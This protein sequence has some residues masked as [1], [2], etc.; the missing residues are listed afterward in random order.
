MDETDP[1][2]GKWKINDTPTADE[3]TSN[4]GYM[5]G[6][7]YFTVEHDHEVTKF[8]GL[9]VSKN[10]DE[11]LEG[12]SY[13]PLDSSGVNVYNPTEGWNVTSE[14]TKKSLTYDLSHNQI[15]TIY[16]SDFGSFS[17]VEDKQMIINWLNANATKITSTV[18]QNNET[19]SIIDGVNV[20]QNDSI[21][22][23]T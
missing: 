14:F 12:I 13:W 18:Y 15:I 2:A 21:L 19:L 17:L 5:F 1:L 6:P 7:I 3:W 22:T 4:K 9:N 16:S 10:S 8:M 11:S 20:S 23:I